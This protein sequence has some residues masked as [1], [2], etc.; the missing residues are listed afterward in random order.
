MKFADVH[1]FFF[2]FHNIAKKIMQNSELIE[3]AVFSVCDIFWKLRALLYKVKVKV[4]PTTGRR[5]GPR[6]SR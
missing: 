5:D 1:A 2:V 4:S 6:G 3:L